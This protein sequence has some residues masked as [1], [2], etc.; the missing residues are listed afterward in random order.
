MK[1]KIRDVPFWYVNPRKVETRKVLVVASET[2]DLSHDVSFDATR[3]QR[4]VL[5]SRDAE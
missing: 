3:V 2:R 4:C 1:G 5:T